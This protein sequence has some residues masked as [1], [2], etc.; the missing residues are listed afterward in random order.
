MG[1]GRGPK[2][3]L[4]ELTQVERATLQGWIRR[5]KTAQASA[6]RARIVLAAPRPAPP[7][8]SSI[9]IESPNAT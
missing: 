5:Q 1:D 2:L 4:L 6:T 3:A 9:D 7:A 8:W